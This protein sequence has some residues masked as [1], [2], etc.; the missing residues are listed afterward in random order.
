MDQSEIDALLDGGNLEEENKKQ[1]DIVNSLIKPA[2]T[3]ASNEIDN[4]PPTEEPEKPKK[5]KKK[6]AV[7]G[8]LS[9]VSQ[10]AE[11]GTTLVMNYL[12]NMLNIA[13]KQKEYSAKL[14]TELKNNTLIKS[15]DEIIA[16][17]KDSS[18]LI[19]DL[20]FNAMDAFQFQDINRQKLMKV[21]HTLTQLN[22]YL[23][24][25]LGDDSVDDDKPL[26]FGRNIEDKT[27][28]TD[29]DKENVDDIIAQFQ[30]SN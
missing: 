30:N 27:L 18:F 28:A 10:E 20:I 14:E 23:N 21:M 16:Y 5:P 19:E 4:I 29:L 12:E 11:E 22:T 3:E 9:K 8:Q 13:T 26:N 24:D 1:Q 15:T 25:L 6:G 2:E 7:M 17:F